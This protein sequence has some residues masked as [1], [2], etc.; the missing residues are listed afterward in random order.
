[1]TRDVVDIRKELLCTEKYLTEN[2]PSMNIYTYNINQEY[3]DSLKK[4]L[5][6]NSSDPIFKPT[7]IESPPDDDPAKYWRDQVVKISNLNNSESIEYLFKV[8]SVAYIIDDYLD[9]AKIRVMIY[10]LV[11]KSKY[12][13]I[14]DE[15]G[16]SFIRKL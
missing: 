7:T 11:I 15:Y 10:P 8:A 16:E 4:Q 5:S 9:I 6:T 12:N 3:F 2:Y 1:M 13:N 14:L